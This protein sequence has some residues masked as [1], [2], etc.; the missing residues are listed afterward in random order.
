MRYQ[1]LLDWLSHH[2]GLKNGVA[3]LGKLITVVNFTLLHWLSVRDFGD[4]IYRCA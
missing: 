3:V 4:L 2:Q 1:V